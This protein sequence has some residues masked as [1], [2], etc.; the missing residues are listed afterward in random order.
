MNFEQNNIPILESKKLNQRRQQSSK[1]HSFSSISF[2]KNI[3]ISGHLKNTR[4]LKYCHELLALKKTSA[5]TL[6]G[7]TL[8]SRALKETFAVAF[9]GFLQH[10]TNILPSLEESI[11]ASC[12]YGVELWVQLLTYLLFSVPFSSSIDIEIDCNSKKC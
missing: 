4:F 3:L 1:C 11:S 8:V 10:V 9:R 7:F 6:K 12:N 5:H 2:L